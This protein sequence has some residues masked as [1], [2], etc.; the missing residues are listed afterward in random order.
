MSKP[1]PED[2]LIVVADGGKAILL[3]NVGKREE[4]VLSEERRLTLKDFV[5]DGPSGAG[6][7]EQSPHET[8]EATFAKQLAKTLNKMF[9]QNLFKA[10]VLIADPQTL[11]Q[12][13]EAVHKNVENAT[14]FT[15]AKDYTNHSLKEMQEVLA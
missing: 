12:L 10:V 14:A 7:E 4:L 11:G 15:L 1:I 9:D 3:R 6:V 2:A 8:S 13:R 5:D